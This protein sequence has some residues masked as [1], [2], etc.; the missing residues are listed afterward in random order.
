MPTTCRSVGSGATCLA[1]LR[2]LVLVLLVHAD[3]SSAGGP[4]SEPPHD[5]SVVSTFAFPGWSTVTT[6]APTTEAPTDAP[7]A[8]AT[9][10]PTTTK[11]TNNDD[12]DDDDD[13]DDDAAG[14]RLLSATTTEA[15]TD[16]PTAT[17]LN[18]RIAVTFAD[19]DY[20]R[21]SPNEKGDFKVAI[22]AVIVQNTDLTD[23]DIKEVVL[24]ATSARR[25]RRATGG[26]DAVI[27]LVATVA[28]EKVRGVGLVA[29]FDVAVTVA[30][31]ATTTKLGAISISATP[32]SNS[33]G[34]SRL[35]P[36]CATSSIDTAKCDTA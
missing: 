15:P 20:T 16:A 32:T 7:T 5:E 9:P 11:A 18:A 21:M 3:V 13:D 30:G 12:G 34:K 19:V 25:H 14:A 27:V 28:G 1:A 29:G 36:R 2:V 24:T 33:T 31:K 23:A 4:A 17:K 6:D 22:Q 26:T 35:T 8:T 10:A